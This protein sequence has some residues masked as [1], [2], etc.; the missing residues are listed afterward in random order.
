MAP[1]PDWAYLSMT[2]K[3]MSGVGTVSSSRKMAGR[4]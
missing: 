1:T 4:T 2:G 3:N